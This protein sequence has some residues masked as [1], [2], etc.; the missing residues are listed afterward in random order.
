M[1]Q[2]EERKKVT[3][4]VL[5]ALEVNS[6]IIVALLMLPINFSGHLLVLWICL[7]PF[8]SMAQDTIVKMNGHTIP[9]T[10]IRFSGN[11]LFYT[12]LANK[13]KHLRAENVFSIQRRDSG[14]KVIYTPDSLEDSFTVPQMRHFVTGER[15]ALKFYRPRMAFAGGFISGLAGGLIA[16]V[17]VTLSPIPPALGATIIGTGYPGVKENK[18]SDPKLIRHPEYIMGYQHKAR[19]IKIRRAAIGG[20]I[21]LSVSIIA[22]ILMDKK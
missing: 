14:E 4:E 20:G 11:K 21:G 8:F 15:D 18:T 17:F 10:Q 13:E 22:L 12:T 9:A 2:E 16:P 6:E 5:P 19:K 1:E 7:I 3:R